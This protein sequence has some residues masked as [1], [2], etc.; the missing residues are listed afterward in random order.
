METTFDDYRDKMNKLAN[1]HEAEAYHLAELAI[2]CE[3]VAVECQTVAD[4]LY[5]ATEVLNELKPGESLN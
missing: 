1:A 4:S 3:S 2:Q 5:K